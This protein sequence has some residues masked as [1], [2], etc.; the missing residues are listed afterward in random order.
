AED[1]GKTVEYFTGR[2]GK[3]NMFAYLL[4]LTQEAKAELKHEYDVSEVTANFD[5]ASYI[6][7][8]QNTAEA[9]KLEIDD[10]KARVISGDLILKDFFRDGKLDN[11]Y[12]ATTFYTD[13]KHIIDRAID[14]RYKLQM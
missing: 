9:N 2:W 12:T 1:K 13:H 11:A 14:S 7:R 4:H 10:V 8:V 5:Y 6:G 3:E